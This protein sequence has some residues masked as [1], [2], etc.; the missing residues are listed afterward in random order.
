MHGSFDG[1]DFG[2]WMRDMKQRLLDVEDSN[3][4]IADWSSAASA[5]TAI[6]RLTNAKIVGHQIAVL[7]RNFIVG[8]LIEQFM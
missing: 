4:I 8:L 7:L 1:L 5:N 2:H 3:V 6:N